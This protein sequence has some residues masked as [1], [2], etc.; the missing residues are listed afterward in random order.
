MHWNHRVIKEVFVDSETGEPLE[1][2]H[3]I[4]EAYYDEEVSNSVPTSW[5]GVT[6]NSIEGVEGLR[7]Q[8]EHMLR[9]LDKPVLIVADDK[10]EGEEA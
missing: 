10:I 4:V 3:T 9:A 6:L 2:V 5:G 8:L 7:W 1:T